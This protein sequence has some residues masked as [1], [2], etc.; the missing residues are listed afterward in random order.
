MKGINKLIAAVIL[1]MAG[2]FAAVNIT[3]LST[4]DDKDKLFR[5]EVSRIEQEIADGNDVSADNYATISGIYEYDG[6]QD[7]YA[8][9]NE[10]V[11]REIDG[12][13]YRIDHKQ[14]KN[15]SRRRILI[16]VN[17]A[18]GI[19]G[20]A[21]ILLLVHISHS[22]LR[23]FSEISDLPHELAKGNLTVPLKE[24][25]SRYFGKFIWGLD[26]L[27]EKLERSRRQELDKIKAEKTLLLSL[28]H[29]IKTPLSAIKLYSRALSR[30]LYPDEQKQIEIAENIGSRA[31]EIQRF[32]N[33]IIRNSDNDL[34]TFE[35]NMSEFYMSQVI[36]KISVSYKALL[37]GS[38]TTFEVN[39]YS[40]CM[41]SGDPDRLE[42]VLQNI[43]E[44]AVKYGDGHIISL[45]FSHEEN[46]RL[47]T[48][49][50]SGCT[51]PDAELTH[52]FDSFWRGSN[53]GN[54]QGSG[55]GLYIC[56]R[57]MRD[58]GGDIFAQVAN[59]YMSITLVCRKA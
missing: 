54:K 55:L 9:Q 27:R 46:C 5:V 26:M 12:K 22:I 3:L 35:I 39:G 43:I 51:L 2:V 37:S 21:I 15:N 18:L 38:G 49:S 44:N 4:S 34:L 50:N 6:S 36:N 10:Y 20:A 1:L 53:V 59:G 24:N 23:P 30:G 7:F 41:L 52:I 17:T 19:L 31:D 45:S 11:I 8:T 16:R 57:L 40:D 42:E 25:K 48:V 32:V 29:D 33:E 47:I 14:M 13:T 56:R 58:M 28:S